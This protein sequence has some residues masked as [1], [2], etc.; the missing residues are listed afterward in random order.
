MQPELSICEQGARSTV[1]THWAMWLPVAASWKGS[2]IGGKPASVPACRRCASTGTIQSCETLPPPRPT[3][4]RLEYVIQKIVEPWK[5]WMNGAH[6]G[7]ELPGVA[8][9]AARS[10]GEPPSVGTTIT[11]ASAASY[12]LV[13]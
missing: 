13:F 2:Q 9:T 1:S 6:F 12:E 5:W 11:R 3:G 10:T 8:L 7:H 4:C